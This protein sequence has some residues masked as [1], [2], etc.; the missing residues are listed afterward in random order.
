MFFNSRSAAKCAGQRI[1]H[2]HQIWVLLARWVHLW[3]LDGVHV[4]LLASQSVIVVVI[5]CAILASVNAEG[6][7]HLYTAVNQETAFASANKLTQR[8][9]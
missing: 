5:R 4:V 6:A 3:E 1:I 8:R 9:Q 7:M 2:R